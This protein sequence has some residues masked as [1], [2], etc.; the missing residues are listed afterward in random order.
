MKTMCGWIAG[1][2]LALGACGGDSKTPAEKCDDLV[3]DVCVRAM[4][5]VGTSTTTCVQEVKQSLSCGSV[6]S[7]TSTYGRCIDQINTD[8]CAVLFP[9][10]P[11][12]NNQP[13]LTLPADCKGVLLTQ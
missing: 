10:D 5:C 4:T 12:N 6:K 7:V 11:N 8:A 9:P 3:N 13:T 2:A 1:I